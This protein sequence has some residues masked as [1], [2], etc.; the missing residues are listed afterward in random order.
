MSQRAVLMINCSAREAFIVREC[1]EHERRTISAYVLNVVLRAV[2]TEEKY[3]ARIER[4]QP[5][6]A[7]ALVHP[8]TCLLVRCSSEEAHR[9]RSAA[10]RREMTMCGYVLYALE[11]SWTASGARVHNISPT[12]GPN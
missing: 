8:R 9:I 2:T 3:L 6:P 11:R 12:A 1:A 7:T 4:L 5:F 10:K